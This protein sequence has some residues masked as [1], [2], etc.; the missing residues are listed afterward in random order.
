MSCEACRKALSSESGRVSR[1]NRCVEQPC[2]CEAYSVSNYSPGCVD[3]DE[4]LHFLVPTPEGR[5]ENGYLNPT[6]LISLNTEGLS[7]LRDS[8]DD[9]EFEATVSELRP[10]WED[11]KRSLEGI[12]SF[13]ASAVRHLMGQRLC[14][15]YDTGM[16]GKPNHADLMAPSLDEAAA[17]SRTELKRLQRARVKQVIDQIG[18][19]FT[20][21]DVFRDGR[22]AHLTK[23]LG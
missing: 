16:P 17:G 5:T 7:V 1:I 22:L 4:T 19:S 6:F 14:C 12:M 11:R 23:P 9:V 20:A 10:R 13:K 18:N 21:A 3:D 15:V 2:G 8:A